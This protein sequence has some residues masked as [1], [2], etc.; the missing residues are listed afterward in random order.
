M[1]GFAGFY[2]AG[3]EAQCSK[4]LGRSTSWRS[5]DGQDYSAPVISSRN[6]CR[7]HYVM[8]PEENGPDDAMYFTPIGPTSDRQS[9]RSAVPAREDYFEFYVAYGECF[10]AWSGVEFNLL[11]VYVLLMSSCDYRVVSAAYYSTTGFRAK[12]EMVDVVLKNSSRVTEDDRKRWVSLFKGRR[13]GE[14]WP[15]TVRRLLATLTG[16]HHSAQVT[17]S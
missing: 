10:A 16:R 7:M 2:L 12:L 1:R 5:C 3:R 4:S 13:I 9:A 8:S 11:A 15:A 6:V 14:L 17:Q